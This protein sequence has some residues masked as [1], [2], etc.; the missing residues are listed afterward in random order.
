MEGVV[1]RLSATESDV[2]FS[3]RP[4]HSQIGAWAS[5]QSSVLSSR[6]EI[7]EKERDIAE[8]FADV[9]QA[10]PRPENWGGYVVVPLSVE[11]WQGRA[12]RLHDRCEYFR[13]TVNAAWRRRRLSP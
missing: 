2:Y 3:T 4:R 11:F 8:R 12:G 1:R 7:D 6:Q 10:I 5:Q 9:S 13:D